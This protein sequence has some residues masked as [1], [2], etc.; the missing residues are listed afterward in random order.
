MGKKILVVGQG[1]REHALVWKLAQSPAV[2][3]IYAAPGNPGI[4]QLAECL[5]ISASDGE[6]LL[7]FAQREGID[8]T[9]VGPE[10]ALMKGIVDAFQQNGLK[11]FG[12]SARAARLEG[13][14]VFA[15]D[16]MQKYGIP[17]AA[18]R[19]FDN[20]EQAGQFA[21]SFTDQG[22]PVVI[23]A[24]GLAAG[25]GVVVAQNWEEARQALDDVMKNQVFGEAG[26]RVVVEECLQGEEVSVFA[27]ADGQKA[28][29]LIAAQ[30]HKRVYDQDRGPNTG[31]MGAYT[32]PPVY[33]RELHER[34]DRTILQPTV[35][36]MAKEGCPYCG[37]LYAGLMLTAEGPK[38]LEFNA[39]FGDP[40]TQ[41]IMPSIDGDLL[42][43]LEAV[44]DRDLPDTGVPLKPG[45][46]VCVVLASGGY[47]GDYEKGL[48]IDGLADLDEHTLVFH[49]GT[50][51]RDGRLVTQGG[52]V[53]AVGMLAGSLP[54][55]LERVYREIAKI[56]FAGMH[57]RT[58]IGQR[59]LNRQA[60]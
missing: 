40:E 23:K 21:R 11:I 4:A 47:P 38:V 1:G 34:V 60:P 50:A 54:T 31:G 57:F 14:K 42:P 18:Y 58:D 9:V 5:D 6:G 30:D 35:Q 24:D 46:C 45:H 17:T 32:H 41:V 49:A 25:K 19:V 59:A 29:T 28:V 55:A 16:L 27:L 44:A 36:A 56:S 37:V 33:T 48:P 12:P 53:M 8:L 7:R 3:K 10:E 51:L 15:K 2:E 26:Q 52:R 43:W 39:R 22:L 13:S 20:P